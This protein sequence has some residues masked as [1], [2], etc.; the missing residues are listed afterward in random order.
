MTELKVDGAERVMD[1][2]ARAPGKGITATRRLLVGVLG[3]VLALAISSVALADNTQS[4]R[5]AFQPTKVPRKELRGGSLNVLATTGTTGS[6]TG[7]ISPV[8]RARVFFDKDF[9]FF[10]NGIRRCGLSSIQGTTTSQARSKC[11]ASRVGAGAGKVQIAG[12]PNPANTVSAQ[13]TAFNGS[14]RNGRP[15]ILLHSRVDALAS[16][17]VLV[18]VLQNTRRPYGKMLNVSVPVLPAS[19]ALTRFQ[20]RVQKRFK[21]RGRNRQYVSA[22][23]SRRKWRYKGVFNYAG[24]PS[25]TKYASQGCRGTRR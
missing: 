5:G 6:G 1:R 4:V 10:T 15:T 20:V 16:T 19:S 17:V 21:F 2:K 8:T 13:I 7:S 14:P 18:G 11:R 23:C 24:A 9:A 22:R 12:D 25:L 3:L